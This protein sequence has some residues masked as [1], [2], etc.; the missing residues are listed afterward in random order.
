MTNHLKLLTGKNIGTYRNENNLSE[1][2]LYGP[3]GNIFDADCITATNVKKEL[4]NMDSKEVTIH[5][6][7][8]GGD[9]FEGIAVYNVLKQSN[10]QLTVFIDGIAASAASIIAMAGDKIKMPKNTQIMIHN[11]ATGL[12]GNAKDF[13]IVKEQLESTNESLKTTYRDRFNGTEDQLKQFMADET[14]FSAEQALK[15]GLVDEVLSY[16]SE[17]LTRGNEKVPQNKSTEF[18]DERTIKIT[19]Q[20]LEERTQRFAA[21]VN[22][23]NKAFGNGRK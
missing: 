19:K 14:F 6:H 5:I 23:L 10:K 13:A 16:E 18:M 4:D 22:A 2:Y 9:A 1:L 8:Y 7:S 15:Y 20:V 17:P 21:F 11:A 12:F 3:V